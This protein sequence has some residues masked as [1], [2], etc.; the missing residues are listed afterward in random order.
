MN[1]SI[2]DE[3]ADKMV[4]RETVCNEAANLYKPREIKLLL[5]G[6]SPPITENYFYKMNNYDNRGQSLPAK[7]LRG[8]LGEQ[9]KFCRETHLTGLKSL[10]SSGIFLSDICA[11]PID[12]F[13]AQYR[14]K[15]IEKSIPDLETKMQ[16]LETGKNEIIWVLPSA[17]RKE[18]SLKKHMKLRKNLEELGLSDNNFVQWS[19][20]ENVLIDYR[21][22]V[23]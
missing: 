9:T 16:D 5:I 10:K 6:E 2:L 11:F 23:L 22:L 4:Q 18:L 3:L 17:T 15:F 14:V 8:L 21:H 19:N 13:S 20:I 1:T 7:V 12:A